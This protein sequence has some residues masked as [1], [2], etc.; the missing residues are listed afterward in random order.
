MKRVNAVALAGLGLES[1][2]K[3]DDIQVRKKMVFLGGTCNGS[4]WRDRIAA[5]LKVDFFN[6]VVANYSAET[7]QIE[8]EAK[9]QAA[10]SLYTIT[11]K[12]QGFYAFAELMSAAIRDPKNTVVA[13]LDE[14]DGEKFDDDLKKS[15]EATKVLLKEQTGT[16]VV[17][18]LP[19]AA[20]IINETILEEDGKDLTAPAS[21]TE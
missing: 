15:V 9:K 16:H 1:E 17:E 5:D 11:P 20:K 13:F 21:G 14:D 8:E 12:Q 4:D 2:I 6:P 18:S 19:E 10:M 7:Q 3:P